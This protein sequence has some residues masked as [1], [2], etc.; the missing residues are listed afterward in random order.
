MTTAYAHV[1][2]PWTLLAAITLAAGPLSGCGPEVKEEEGAGTRGPLT[3]NLDQNNLNTKTREV[4][5]A[6]VASDRVRQ[7]VAQAGDRPTLGFYGVRNRTSAVVDT[8]IIT[9]LLKEDIVNCGLFRPVDIDMRESFFK[10]MAASA[11]DMFDSASVAKL[12][13]H[14]GAQFLLSGKLTAMDEKTPDVARSQ[15]KLVMQLNN[16]STGEIV[17]IHGAGITKTIE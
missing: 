17:F 16:V 14:Y 15:Y 4:F 6:F 7:A 1:L 8:E 9:D 5:A 12:G 10:E 13:Q 3:R 2:R 11:G